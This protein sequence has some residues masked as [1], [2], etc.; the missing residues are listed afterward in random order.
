M[1]TTLQA[2]LT[3]LCST[4]HKMQAIVT[5]L[6]VLVDD[7]SN[8]TTCAETHAMTL[9]ALRDFTQV[10]AM[11]AWETALRQRIAAD[12]LKEDA[13]EGSSMDKKLERRAAM[14]ALSAWLQQPYMDVERL[15]EVDELWSE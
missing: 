10:V 13:A 6:S 2:S 4:L 3:K 14:L 11:Y 12:L 8:N 7:A 5:R 15:A 9:H 1:P